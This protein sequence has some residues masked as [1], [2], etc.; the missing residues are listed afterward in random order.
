MGG[1]PLAKTA[2]R[3]GGCPI[4]VDTQGQAGRGSEQPDLAVSVPVH[5]REVGLDGL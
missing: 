1:E 4:P 2:H 5:C 3:G